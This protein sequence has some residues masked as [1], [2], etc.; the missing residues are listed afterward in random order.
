MNELIETL[1]PKSDQLNATDLIAGPRRLKITKVVLNDDPKQKA[2]IFFEGDNGKPYKPCLSMRRLL[3]LIYG[4]GTS[5]TGKEIVVFRDPEVVYAGEKVGGIVISHASHI[6]T[7]QRHVLPVSKGKNRVYVVEPLKTQTKPEPQPTPQETPAN[8]LAD[9]ELA[10]MF[11]GQE[12]AVLAF[13]VNV[14]GWL[15]DTQSLADLPK[16]RLAEIKARAKVFAASA[17]ITL[18]QPAS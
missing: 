1:A 17:G 18:K 16:E 14:K 8:T 7:T 2:S 12:S 15:T 6:T 4:K 13:L 3:V 5:L 11:A 9:P 10:E